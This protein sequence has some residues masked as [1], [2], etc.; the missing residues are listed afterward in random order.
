MSGAPEL[1]FVIPCYN[2]AKRLEPKLS[3]SLA[4]LETEVKRPFEILFVDDGSTDG[5]SDVL[6]TAAAKFPGVRIATIRY[7]PNRGKGRA[8]K[9]G[10]LAARG[11]KILV[12]DADFSV[13]TSEIF[14]FLDALDSFPVVIGTKKHLLTQTVKAQDDT[15]SFLG[16]GFTKLTNLFLGMNFTDITCGLKG[17]RGGPGRDIF[18]RQRI[19]RWSY[20]SETL[21]LARRLGYEVTEIPVK[22]RHEED[23]KVRTFRAVFSSAG[24]LLA[25]RLNALSGRYGKRAC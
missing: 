25:I 22:W 12:L 6:A 18:G 23:S 16:R 19:N 17:F 10:V 5:T 13:E 9:T 24:E 3:E 2:E 7:A 1:T 4:Y 11:D 14:R 15:R 20:D 21:F 8:V